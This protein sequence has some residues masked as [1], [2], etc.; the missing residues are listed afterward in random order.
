MTAWL[1]RSSQS[2]A[3]RRLAGRV[4]PPSARTTVRRLVLNDP[5]RPPLL[6]GR[7]RWGNLRRTQPFSAIYGFDRGTP[8]DRTYI[9][10]FLATYS[11]DIRGEILE[12]GGTTYSGTLEKSGAA[13]THVLDIDPSNRRATIIADLA[14][15]GSLPEARFDCFLLVQTLQYVH[16][17]DAG[18]RNAWRALV[19]GGT[20]LI[21]V[22]TVSKVDAGLRETDLWRF[23][24]AGLEHVLE[25]ACPDGRIEVRGY[26]NLLATSAFLTG[27]STGELSDDEIRFDDP[28]FP[29]LACARVRKP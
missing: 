22:P 17:V 20:L 26:G 27:L 9:A 15:P 13:T 28:D 19:P 5:P 29:L 14:E 2:V 4:V 8:I 12:I 24:P 16:D 6:F 7:P 23:T 3:L 18:L 11:S 25:V 10:D 21:T 1:Q